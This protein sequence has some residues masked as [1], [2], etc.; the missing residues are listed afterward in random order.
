MVYDN[1]YAVAI[2]VHATTDFFSVMHG[3]SVNVI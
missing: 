1:A 3:P 2:V